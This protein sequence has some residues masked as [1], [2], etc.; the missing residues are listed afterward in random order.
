MAR[1]TIE[2]T[3]VAGHGDVVI[4]NG[5]R[6]T[7]SDGRAVFELIEDVS[8]LSGVNTATAIFVAQTAGKSFNDYAIGTISV[9]LDPQSYLSAV[10]NLTI[11]AGGSDEENDEQLRSRIKLAP[12]AFSNAGSRKAYEFWAKSAS[13]LIIDVAIQ[14]QKCTVN[15]EP[16]GL[17]IGDDIPGTVEVFPL[18]ESLESTPMEILTAVEAVLTDE[19]IRP[20]TD[21]VIV[22]S[23]TVIATDINIGLILY[24][25]AVQSDV[26]PVVLKKITDFKSLRKKILGQDLVLD[27]LKAL[28]MIDGVYKTSVT[29]PATDLVVLNTEFVKINTINITVTG[30][31]IG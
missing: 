15:N 30:T 11:T 29:S 22:S 3:L 6:V 28:C 9:I 24:D 16:I 27:Q 18:I 14:N 7:S 31:N 8:V 20:L 25:W 10:S 12:S 26:L 1:T 4:P 23:P 21:T 2:F 13:P 17:V 19:K 5:M